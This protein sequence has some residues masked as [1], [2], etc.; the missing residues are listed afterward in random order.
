[1]KSIRIYALLL[2]LVCVLG[3]ASSCRKIG[4]DPNKETEPVTELVTETKEPETEQESE[5]VVD[6][7][8]DGIINIVMVGDVLIHERVRD[9][10]K[11]A[12]GSL[13]YDHLFANLYDEINGAD[14]SIVNQEVI[15]GGSELGL[16][17][18]PSF[19]G[20][21]EM[22]DALVKAGFD[23]VL[24][25]T[26][27]ALDKGK[28]GLLNCLNFWDTQYPDINVV[29]IADSETR[30][31]EICV[32]EDEGIKVAILNYTYGMNGIALPADMPWCVNM[33]TRDNEASIREDIKKAKDIADYVIV[34]PHWGTEYKHTTDASQQ[35]W[36]AVFFE[37]GV[38]LVLGTHP[39]VVE[40]VETVTD[41]SHS[42]LVYYSL[43]N[44]VN[45]TASKGAGV[46][47]R[48]LGAMADI[49]LEKTDAGVSLVDYGVLPIVSHVDTTEA[50]KLTVYRLDEYTTEL[51]AKNEIIYQDSSFS[52]DYLIGICR[53][54]FGELY[55]G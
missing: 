41:G 5:P 13:N 39:H 9:S 8:S 21:F 45:S 52:L 6:F 46:A 42:M 25:A 20:A 24:H 37:C 53:E 51:A 44:Y 34:A 40:G 27:H 30:S 16:T 49:T 3:S 43:G 18:Y 19:N 36:T 54:V 12:D 50:G 7:D 33:L 1:M 29:G 23:V 26:N 17:G 47:D 15:L 2:A 10:G 38:D 35:Y 22:G 28:T 32:V 14:I 55:E 48:M 31:R 4:D 11:M